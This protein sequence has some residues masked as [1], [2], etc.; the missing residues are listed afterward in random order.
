MQLYHSKA[1]R[2]GNSLKLF[3]DNGHWIVANCNINLKFNVSQWTFLLFKLFFIF[4]IIF[5]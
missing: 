2:L 4:L 5:S 3:L 1:K